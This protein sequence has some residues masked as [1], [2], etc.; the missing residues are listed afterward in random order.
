MPVMLVVVLLVII[1]I[2]M[3][4]LAVLLVTRFLKGRTQHKEAK[5]SLCAQTLIEAPLDATR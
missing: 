4:L 1:I 5:H 2:L 3:L